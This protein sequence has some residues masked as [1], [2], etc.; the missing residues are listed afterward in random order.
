[1]LDALRRARGTIDSLVGQIEQMRGMFDDSD[2][3]IAEAIEE[4]EETSERLRNEIARATAPIFQQCSLGLQELCR[5]AY[6]EAPT[7][8]EQA[9]IAR[10][11]ELGA[12]PII[13][14][15]QWRVGQAG[16][17]TDWHELLGAA[18]RQFCEEYDRQH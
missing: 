2:G 13:G 8:Q 9:I 14:L 12:E 1:M 7:H 16:I 18:C 4:A 15:G 5:T 3:A 6:V 17:V 11:A 10:A